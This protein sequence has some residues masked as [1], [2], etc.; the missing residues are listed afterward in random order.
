M[1]RNCVN[2]P[3]KFCYIC[4]EVTFLTQKLPLTPVV[5]EAYEWYFGYKV[6]DH[7]KKWAP[8]VCCISCATILRE[9]LNNKGRSMRFALPMI[10]REPTDHLIDCYF[11]I[12]P[13]LRHG[14]TEKERELSI[15]LKFRL[16]FD[17]YPTLKTSLFQYHRSRFRRRAY[18]NPG[19]DTT[20]F[21]IYWCWFYCWS[22]I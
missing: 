18:R 19:Q 9:W 6:G 22:S 8:H 16:L 21:N 5:K 15:I 14:N 1:T 20:T 12:P 13:P 2:S 4:G 10:R 7:D 3:D 17:R 11:C